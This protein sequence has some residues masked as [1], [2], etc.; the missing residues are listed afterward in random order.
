MVQETERPADIALD[1]LMRGQ[2]SSFLARTG[3]PLFSCSVPP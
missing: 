3:L 2:D 1:H